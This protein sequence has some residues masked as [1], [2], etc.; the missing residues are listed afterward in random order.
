MISL[1][2]IISF[3]IPVAILM[4]IL[5]LIAL[6]IK[7]II[8]LLINVILGGII[9]FALSA[10]GIVTVALTWWMAAIVG[11]LGVPGA[12]IVAILAIFVI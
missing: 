2:A 4:L 7:I 9:L 11:F 12:I 8:H 6:P 10:A 1:T 3:L 5:K